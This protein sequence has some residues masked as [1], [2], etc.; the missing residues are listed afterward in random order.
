MCVNDSYTISVKLDG[1]LDAFFGD[2]SYV[3]GTT[4]LSI[5]ESLI[6]DG[7]VDLS[8]NSA[9]D[10]GVVAHPCFEHKIESPFTGTH[11]VLVVRVVDT[12]GAEPSLSIAD[13]SHKTF[14]DNINLV[15]AE[16]HL[17]LCS[18]KWAPEL[19]MDH[20]KNSMLPVPVT[21]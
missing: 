3:L 12:T 10:I 1:D 21:N 16:V 11:K 5:P 4:Q 14:D 18:L 7:A 13:L 15:S 2:Y 9:S 17:I 19:T 6:V 20:R 8:A